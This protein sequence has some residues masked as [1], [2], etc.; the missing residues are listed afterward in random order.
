VQ[1]DATTAVSGERRGLA[2]LLGV[3][4]VLLL[5]AAFRWAHHWGF[6]ADSIVLTWA[7]ATLGGLV[8]S[9]RSLTPGPGRRAALVGL[10]PVGVSL[11]ALVV[12]G[13]AMAAGA[14]PAGACGGL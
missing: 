7:V 1:A 3:A 2:P 13:I 9:L 10:A 5:A 4:S 11:G 6:V 8:V 12:T 14:D